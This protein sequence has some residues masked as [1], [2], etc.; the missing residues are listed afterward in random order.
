MHKAV[1]SRDGNQLSLHPYQEEFVW[2]VYKF[3]KNISNKFCSERWRWED[4]NADGQS[5][6][7]HVP[8]RMLFSRSQALWLSSLPHCLQ[9]KFHPFLPILSLM[10]ITDFLWQY[11]FSP[12]Y[13]SQIRKR[14]PVL[15]F[16]HR[17]LAL[18]GSYTI[19][20]FKTLMCSLMKSSVQ[21]FHTSKRSQVF[22]DMFMGVKFH[23][24]DLRQLE[25]CAFPASFTLEIFHIFGPCMG[26]A[27]SSSC[28]H[29]YWVWEAQEISTQ[30]KCFWYRGTVKSAQP[31]DDRSNKRRQF[32]QSSVVGC[33]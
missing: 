21:I 24:S 2:H 10:H 32:T 11:C 26:I 20:F 14:R 19:H 23:C 6:P 16:L 30:S 8:T 9:H 3:L 29:S 1:A 22:C 31:L 15:S 4:R 28:Y 17:R 33:F 25:I 7:Y 13:S 5:P 12:F 18:L 27:F